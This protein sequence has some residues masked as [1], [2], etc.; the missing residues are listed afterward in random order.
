MSRGAV[1]AT[2]NFEVY[3]L[4]TMKLRIKMSQ[5]Q[6]QLEAKLASVGDA[7]Y[8]HERLAEAL[9]RRPPISEI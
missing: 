8:I 6:R 2:V 5:K 1:G 9:G 7:E 3:L 4:L